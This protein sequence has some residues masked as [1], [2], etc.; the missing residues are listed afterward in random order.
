MPGIAEEPAE[1]V[2]VDEAMPPEDKVMDSGLR[3]AVTFS[4][5]PV[6]ERS[7]VSLKPFR[8]VTFIVELPDAP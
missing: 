2:R 6:T 4:G 7:T 5:A 3:L 1:I 8:D